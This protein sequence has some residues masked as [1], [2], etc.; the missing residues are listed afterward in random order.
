MKTCCF[1]SWQDGGCRQRC[2]EQPPPLLLSVALSLSA[3]LRGP[4]FLH[5][6]LGSCSSKGFKSSYPISLKP[7]STT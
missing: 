2:C 4:S 5:F 6:P 3:Y 7:S 1:P